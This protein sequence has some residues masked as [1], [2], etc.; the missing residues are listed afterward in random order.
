MTRV[1]SKNIT[2]EILDLIIGI[3]DGW[4]GKLTWERL[5]DEIEML[6]NVKYTRQTL[7]KHTRIKLAFQNSKSRVEG[8]L[9]EDQEN[10][11]TIALLKKRI[12]RLEIENS[13]LQLENDRLLEQFVRWSYNAH[14]KGLDKDFLNNPLPR[15]DREQTKKSK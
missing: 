3:L 8:D 15:V 7:F 11:P 12:D 9:S 13:R 14:L 2:N 1:R 10:N 6:S 4:Q 5:I